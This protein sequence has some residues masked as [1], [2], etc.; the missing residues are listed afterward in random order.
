[1]RTPAPA[2]G[3]AGQAA[4]L[5]AAAAVQEG[6]SQLQMN[7]RMMDILG[8]MMDRKRSNLRS[9]EAKMSQSQMPSASNGNASPLAA[10]SRS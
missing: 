10:E 4:A 7:S 9:L 6:G 1:M 2:D 3:V 5:A 8:S